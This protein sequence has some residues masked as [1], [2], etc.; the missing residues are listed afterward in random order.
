L[1][2]LALHQPVAVDLRFVVAV[3]K[4]SNDLER[5]GDLTANIAERSLSLFNFQPVAIVPAILEM[6]PKCLSMLK[7][8]IDALINLDA[9]LAD[10]VC[11]AD[12]KV[13]TL[14]AS[15]YEDVQNTIKETCED[16]EPYLNMLGISRYLERIADHA[17]NIAE[18]V[19]YMVNGKISRH[20]SL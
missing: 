4:I 8:S 15:M 5:I 18:D 12:E 2:I 11:E 20:R 3:L 6:A 9:K 17:T 10:E 16:I 19:I 1:K 13:D 14:H 7:N